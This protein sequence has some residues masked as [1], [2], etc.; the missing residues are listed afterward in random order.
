MHM[1]S[2][3]ELRHLRYFLA[4]AEELHFGRAALRLHL[5]QPALSQQIRRLE[6][7]VGAPLLR[8]TSRSVA[9]TAAGE[10]FL[11]RT[12]RTLRGVQHDVEEARSI[13]RGESGSLNVG[14]IGSGMLGKLPAVLQGYR[15]AYPRVQL[16]L[17][18]SFTSRVI[19]G[20]A[21][22]TLDAGLLRDSDPHADLHTE[23]L[24]TE[25]FVAVL[26]ADH[27]RA[28][29][30]SIAPTALRNEPFVFYS[31]SAGTLA[32]DKPLA[33]C[34]EAGF[35]PR[36]VQEASNWVSILKLI[37]VGFGVSIAPACVATVE[38]EGVVCLP[39]RGTRE[40]S[41]VELAY[42]KDENR[43]IVSAFAA[44]ARSVA[45]KRT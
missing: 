37:A 13:G 24:F 3:I 12:R 18:E 39:L 7:I 16:Q 26:P 10:I 6:E 29:Q 4:V 9:L 41:H 36:V 28:R 19:A 11:E 38:S 27:P 35:R 2:D 17:H 40:V 1:D 43:P 15:A 22:G 8:R 21:T 20:L 30:S 45:S 23:V 34:G 33:L 44:I 32:W 42:R 14:F 31:R 5:A 25:R